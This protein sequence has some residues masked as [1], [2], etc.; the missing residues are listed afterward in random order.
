M[1]YLEVIYKDKPKT[2]YPSQLCKY[3]FDRF[4]MKFGDKL[5]DVGAG[6]GEFTKGFQDLGIIAIPVDRPVDFNKDPLIGEY[7]F[8]FSKSV[9][10]HLEKPDNFLKESYKVLK[11]NGRI[12]IMTP[13]WQSQMHIFYN[14]Y[15]H[16]RPY[17]KNGLK[18]LLKIYD[19]KEVSSE[20]FYQLPILWK[21]PLLKI[22]SKCLQIFPVKREIKN[23][24]I[25]WSREL[26]ILA[27]G[28]KI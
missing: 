10:E 27:T 25:R 14:D 24:F 23:K 22:I 4:G 11:P 7:D 21:Y 17:D 13:D 28:T 12:I 15:T 16:V 3:L 5:L 18:D 1:K 6:R 9:I 26:M 20:K 19:F 2:K 8:V